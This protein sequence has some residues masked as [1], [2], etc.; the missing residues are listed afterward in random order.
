MDTNIAKQIVDKVFG[1]VFGYNN[2]LTLEQVLAKFAFDVRL[3]Q[4]VYETETNEPTWAQSIN[5]TKFIKHA[6]T[7]EKPE[8]YYEREKRPINS[9]QDILAY[10]SETNA[11]ATERYMDSLNVAESD[12]IRF[13]ENVFR[14]QNIERSKNIVFT[15]GA[16][17]CEYLV[18]SQRSQ[19]STF[20]VRVE[21]SNQC[22][23][24]FNVT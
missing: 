12:D 22:A 14:S 13:S 8:K 9:M 23:N 7:L 19:A 15:D 11:M 2:P 24:S 3:P 16:L 6:S 1:Q 5:P 17:N 18:G 21:D 4:Q 10:W 20:C